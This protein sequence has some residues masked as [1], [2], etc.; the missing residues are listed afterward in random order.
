MRYVKWGF[1]LMLATLVFGFLHYT[2]PQTDIVRIVGTENRRVDIGDNSIFWSR[3]EVGMANSTSRDVFFINA[4][5]PNGRT[6]E[7]RNE[8]TGWGWPP[9]F[10]INSFGLQTQAKE[11]VST[12][13]APVWV[14][15]RHYGW[16]N[17][18]FT[19]FPNAVSIK[20][21]AGPDVTLI[22]WLNIVILTFLAFVL[23]M[24]RRVWLQFRER[25][26]DPA[27]EDV[28]ETWD[29][30]DARADAARDRAKGVFG[31]LWA[32]LASWRS[33]PRK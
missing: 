14:A 18:F 8:D 24:I 31:S 29:A 21:V 19:I 25:T 5:Y 10:K 2:L 32:W 17:Q 1:W 11:A 16:R 7:Y 22:P 9:Y 13:A 30:V 6:M 27:L 26:I 15:L 23:F 4:V 33:K 28:A 3:A 12:D 20:R